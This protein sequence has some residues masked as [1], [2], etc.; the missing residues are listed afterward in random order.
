MTKQNYNRIVRNCLFQLSKQFEI[1]YVQ[2]FHFALITLA[3]SI[4]VWYL[5]F[6][7]FS[8]NH[9]MS[10]KIIL[11][12]LK[13]TSIF[14]VRSKCFRMVRSSNQGWK[15]LRSRPPVFFSFFLDIDVV[16]FYISIFTLH[17]QKNG[18]GVISRI[19]DSDLLGKYQYNYSIWKVIFHL[20]RIVCLWKSTKQWKNFLA[21]FLKNATMYLLIIIIRYPIAIKM[22]LLTTQPCCR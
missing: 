21:S 15:N 17:S 22:M 4:L 10:L 11:R 12:S 7:F 5:G 20:W 8:T 1:V 19:T 2:S 16:I 13:F 18:R 6:F 9:L 14:L 3:L